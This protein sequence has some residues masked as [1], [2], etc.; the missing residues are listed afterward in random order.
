MFD[1]NFWGPVQTVQAFAPLLIAA[2]QSRGAWGARI[3]N[4]GSTAAIAPVPFSAVYNAS[5]G[6]LHSFSDTLRVEL[7]PFK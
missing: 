5:K 7:A 6:A 4:V 2:A 3:V 1:A